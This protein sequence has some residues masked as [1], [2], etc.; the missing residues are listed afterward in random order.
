MKNERLP[1]IQTKPLHGSQSKMIDFGKTH[2]I[3]TLKKIRRNSELE[4]LILSYGDDI[5]VVEPKIFRNEMKKRVKAMFDKY[6]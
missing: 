1:Y 4:S 5:E 3:I 6:N 2:S